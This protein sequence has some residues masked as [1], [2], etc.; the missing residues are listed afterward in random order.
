[1]FHKPHLILSASQV[2]LLITLALTILLFLSFVIL[3]TVPMPC[4]H[5]AGAHY[6][7]TASALALTIL[8]C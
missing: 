8:T 3:G 6:W 2:S 7:F 4:A 5:Q 1:M